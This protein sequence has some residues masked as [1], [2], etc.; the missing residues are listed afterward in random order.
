MIDRCK[1]NRFRLHWGYECEFFSPISLHTPVK[2]IN[3]ICFIK[4]S[5][6]RA[7]TGGQ[8][9][10]KE[11]SDPARPDGAYETWSHKDSREEA[12]SVMER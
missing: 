11:A 12:V 5:I 3:T 8:P 4:L 9:S 2:R 7:M 1:G 10:R 6:S